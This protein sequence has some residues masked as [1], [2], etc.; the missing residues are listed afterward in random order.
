MSACLRWHVGDRE[1]YRR[2]C[3]EM[4]DRFG[5]ASDLPAA[6]DEAGHERVAGAR[7]VDRVDTEG[8]LR[9]YAVLAA[10]TSLPTYLVN[11]LASRLASSSG[12]PPR[13]RNFV[14]RIVVT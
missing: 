11:S 9:D 12:L 14:P 8:G 7:G 5:Q 13:Q 3:R 6:Y 1:G 4:L 2:L 10:F